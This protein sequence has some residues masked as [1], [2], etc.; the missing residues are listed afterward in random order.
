M[1]TTTRP[2]YCSHV[3]PSGTKCYGHARKGGKCPAHSG[4]NARMGGRPKARIGL[5]IEEARR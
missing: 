2:T 1:A 4:R 3:R 5:A